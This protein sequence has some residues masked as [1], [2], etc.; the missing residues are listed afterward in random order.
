MQ[1]SDGK[2]CDETIQGL[3]THT[4]DSQ[5][6]ERDLWIPLG[7]TDFQKRSIC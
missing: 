3:D 4:H 7:C 2:F 1:L 6:E 5:L